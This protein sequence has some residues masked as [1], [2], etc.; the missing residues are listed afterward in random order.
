M[1]SNIVVHG[2]PQLQRA[3]KQMEREAAKYARE[4]IEKEAQPIAAS[5]TRRKTQ[6]QGAAL[7]NIHPRTSRSSVWVED[8]TA[9]FTGQRGDFGSL[10]MRRAMLPALYEHEDAVVRGIDSALDMLARRAGF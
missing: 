2:L 3:L 1:A 4:A 5:A 8:K 9:P 10:I 7:G 6:W